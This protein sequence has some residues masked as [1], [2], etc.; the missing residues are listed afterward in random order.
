MFGFSRGVG[1]LVGPLLTGLAIE[2]LKPAGFL[3]FEETQGY[4]AMFGVASA[5]LLVSVPVLRRMNV[6]ERHAQ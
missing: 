2:L 3:V 6:E 4:A 1:V 5:L